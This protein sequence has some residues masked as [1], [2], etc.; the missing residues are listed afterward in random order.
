M[1]R[2]TAL[3]A[4]LPLAL[5]CLP[6]AF[7]GCDDSTDGDGAGGSGGAG[8]VVEGDGGMGGSGG[9][10]GTGGMGG[11]GASCMADDGCP[12]GARCD[13]AQG[14]CRP[15]CGDDRDCGPTARCTVGGFCAEL[16]ACAGPD[17]CAAGSVCDC[18]GVCVPA[19][20]D[21]CEVDLQCDTVDYC[22]PCTGTCTPRARQCEPCADSSACDRRANCHPVGAAG[23][24]HCLQRCQGN[25]ARFGPGYECLPVDDDTSL[26][27]PVTR[28]CDAID[29]CEADA[30]CPGGR[31]C[32]DG[33][34]QIGCADDANCP[35]G[36]ICNAGRCGPPC[37][38]DGQCEAPAVCQDDGRCRV[39]G[40]CTTSADCP[41]PATY[42]D[43]AMGMCVPGC[44]VDDDCQ[45]AT[46]ECSAGSCVVRGCTGAFQCGFGEICDLETNRCEM[47]EGRHCEPG[48]DPMEENSCGGEGR[49]CLSLQEEDENGEVVML[50]DFCFEPCAE[51]PN[52][53]PQGYQCVELMDQDGNP[54][55]DVCIRRCDLDPFR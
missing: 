13:T 16:P 24:G 53:C 46:Q 52:A 54:M 8:G 11:A 36:E 18:N 10:G 38:G 28:Q 44:E 5:C 40:G 26:C 39:P 31:I 50:G 1:I 25:C 3:T 30:D 49:R 23:L 37:E 55:G 32:N 45:D 2:R 33:F 42:C 51:P 9:M 17:D 12:P 7:F 27:V 35:V 15:S 48:C 47:A 43:R 14:I 4:C 41:E 6:L 19:P 22:D 29:E 20:G 34:C 21:P